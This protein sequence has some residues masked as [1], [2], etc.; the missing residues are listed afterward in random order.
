GSR[1]IFANKL[2]E[3]FNELNIT[4]YEI[5]SEERFGED[6]IKLK[7][8]TRQKE[9]ISSSERKI[10]FK[11]NSNS[12]EDE[13]SVLRQ[14]KGRQEKPKPEMEKRSEGRRGVARK[15]KKV[16][17]KREKNQKKPSDSESED[18]IVVTKKNEKKRALEDQNVS[19][20][21][22]TPPPKKRKTLVDTDRI[23][24]S[25]RGV[26]TKVGERLNFTY[27]AGDQAAR[28]TLTL[29]G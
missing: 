15:P 10:L 20:Q 7:L 3:G 12:D 26:F 22:F 28:T 27:T 2:V 23:E 8:G 17:N 13:M 4:N 19:T 6:Y 18:D 1:K 21:K 9:S 16:Q 29:A 24:K 25:I 11:S 5:K 14:Q